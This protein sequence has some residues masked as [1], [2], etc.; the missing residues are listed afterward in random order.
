MSGLTGTNY[1][2]CM[3]MCQ[4]VCVFDRPGRDTYDNTAVSYSPGSGSDCNGT[5]CLPFIISFLISF[6]I[7][8]H[9][10]LHVCS[11]PAH[12]A[13]LLYCVGWRNG[14]MDGENGQTSLSVD[15]G[16]LRRSHTFIQL[17][18][19]APMSLFVWVPCRLAVGAWRYK[20]CRIPLFAFDV[21]RLQCVCVCVCVCVRAFV[22]SMWFVR[23]RIRMCGFA[24]QRSE[25]SVA[26]ATAPFSLFQP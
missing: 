19:N 26:S 15:V 2:L 9:F 20:E 17:I 5:E 18:T 13:L 7:F 3:Y 21:H 8:L 16:A 10:Q 22:L 14:E 25:T 11:C 23:G 6:C 24:Q 1:P 12:C 4:S